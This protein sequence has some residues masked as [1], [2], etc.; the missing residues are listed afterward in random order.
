[1]QTYMQ[2]Y[3]KE[4]AGAWGDPVNPSSI[5]GRE[6]GEKAGAQGRPSMQ[7]AVFWRPFL[8]ELRVWSLRPSIDWASPPAPTL[9]R[10]VC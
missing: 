6:G 9:W 5:A 1:M 8:G 10:V 3:L 7:S 4:P 2:V